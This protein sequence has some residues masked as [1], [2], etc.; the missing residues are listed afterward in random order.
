MLNRLT[1]VGAAKNSSSISN[2][3]YT[4]G[5]AGNRLTVAELRFLLQCPR[6]ATERNE[7]PGLDGDTGLGN[8]MERW[9]TDS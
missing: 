9:L 4:L 7:G 8:S 6:V 2:Y 1:Q 3:A 5:A